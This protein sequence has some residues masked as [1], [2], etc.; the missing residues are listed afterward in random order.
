MPRN[1][2]P[3]TPLCPSIHDRPPGCGC[4]PR[5]SI[6]RRAKPP[7]RTR[8]TG[9]PP[10]SRSWKARATCPDRRRSGTDRAVRRSRGPGSS[11]AYKCT[12]SPAARH[13]GP[14]TRT[15]HPTRSSRRR[16]VR[17]ARLVQRHQIQRFQHRAVPIGQDRA[18]PA[19]AGDDRPSA[20]RPFPAPDLQ[21]AKRVRRRHLPA[22]RRHSRRHADRQ[23]QHQWR[24]PTPRAYR[25]SSRCTYRFHFLFP[26]ERARR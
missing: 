3:G 18:A 16:F 24:G 23:Q 5:T 26:G 19:R 22:A 7:R 25:A 13:L 14:I 17:A 21:P 12:R 10:S 1:W 11:S 20:G 4:A 8:C 2:Q 15:K 9:R 6:C